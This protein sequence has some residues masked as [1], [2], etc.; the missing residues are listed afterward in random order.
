MKI[1]GEKY[2]SELRMMDEKY[3]F[4]ESQDG[5]ELWVRSNLRGVL[6][7]M[8]IMDEKQVRELG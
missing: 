1:M 4:L 6:G 5:W 3:V 8:Q 7:W 2:V